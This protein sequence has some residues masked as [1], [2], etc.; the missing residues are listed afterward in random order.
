[1]ADKTFNIEHYKVSYNHELTTN[2]SGI[3]INAKGKVTCYGD[4]NRLI[5]YFLKNDIP[6]PQPIYLEN[7]KVGVIFFHLDEIGNYMDILRHEKP[8]Y[9]YFNS[10]KPEW[11]GI[12]TFREPINERDY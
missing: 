8:V 7:D 5:A 3:T 12:G 11:I 10:D 2:C 1:M 6:L 9:A 4:E